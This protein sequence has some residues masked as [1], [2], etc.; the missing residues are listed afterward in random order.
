MAIDNQYGSTSAAD[1]ETE[2][3][4]LRADVNGLADS[5]KRLVQ[6]SPEL[7]RDSVESSI[8]RQPLKAMMIAA[9]VGFITSIV[10]RR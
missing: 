6:E 7:V 10:I 9:G 1:V 8:R 4:A 3:V 5:L 2:L